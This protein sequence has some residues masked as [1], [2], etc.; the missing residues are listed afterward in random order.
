VTDNLEVVQAQDAQASATDR[1]IAARYAV[2]IAQALV[3]SAPGSLEQAIAQY[4]GS[5]TR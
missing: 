3:L 2:T 5:P 1:F 4:L